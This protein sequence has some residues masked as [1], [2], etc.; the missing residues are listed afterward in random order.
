MIIDKEQFFQIQSRFTDI[1]F[2]QSKEWQISIYSSFLDRIQYFTDSIDNP[3][4]CCWGYYSEKI[5]VI[6]KI[7]IKGITKKS[8]ITSSE[9]KSFFKSLIDEKFS[10]ISISDISEYDPNFEVG[11]R[12]AGFV[13]PLGLSVCPLTIIV[14][15]SLPFS[16]HRQWKRSV[17]KSKECGNYFYMVEKPTYKDAIDFE[18]IYKQMSE[19]KILGSYPSANQVFALLGDSF[20]LFFVENKNHERISARIEYKNGNLIYDIWA[21]NTKE[22]LKTGAVYMIQE[23]IFDFFRSQG[24]KKFDYGRIPPSPDYMDDIYLAKTYS[25][26]HPLSYNGQWYYSKSLILT[27]LMSFYQHFV[28]KDRLW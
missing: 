18:Q 6:K 8:D 21:A 15:F 12:R 5:H 20:K 22:A 23:Q 19:R 27:F 17:K 16:F 24:F 2:E 3:R 9:L 14:D 1:P 4:I 25:G 11:I 13:R 26:G 28:R 7:N 10:I